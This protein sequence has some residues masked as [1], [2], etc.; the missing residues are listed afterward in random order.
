M[1]ARFS[2]YPE[3]LSDHELLEMLLYH[4]IP[5]R[6]TNATAHKL[7]RL[8][9]GSLKKL[10]ET[11]ETVLK[12]IE[13]VGDEAARLIRLAGIFAK[14]VNN[15]KTKRQ[16]FEYNSVKYRLIERYEQ[17]PDET[18][19]LFLIDAKG[20]ILAEIPY[21]GKEDVI[22]LPVSELVEIVALYKPAGAALAHNHLSGNPAPTKNDDKTTK[23][24]K[25]MFS[26]H[27]IHLY[28]HIIVAD[29]KAYSYHYAGRLSA[30]ENE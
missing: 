13:G 1:K 29:R 26:L 28:D 23:K 2:V 20:Y 21:E 27:G 19:W 14:R 30:L 18:M 11:D 8:S 7:L 15:E 16:K 10:A 3:S 22:D 4:V 5:R 12:S 9:G 17:E 6:D 25:A 24:I